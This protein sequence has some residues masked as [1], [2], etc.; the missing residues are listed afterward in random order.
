[1]RATDIKL[2]DSAGIRGRHRGP[3]RGRW[4][5]QV[6]EQFGFVALV[7]FFEFFEFFFQPVEFIQLFWFFV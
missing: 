7:Q 2:C 6:I 5:L 3:G 4:Q 1:V